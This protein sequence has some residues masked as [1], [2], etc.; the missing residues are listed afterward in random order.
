MLPGE[1]FAQAME[2]TKTTVESATNTFV[3]A[4]IIITLVLALSL[5]SMWNLYNVI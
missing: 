2:T 1:E 4:Q 5:K 3:V